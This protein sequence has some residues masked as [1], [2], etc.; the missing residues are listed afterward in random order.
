LKSIRRIYRWIIIS[1]FFQ[2]ALLSYINFFYLPGSRDV[3]ATMIETDQDTKTSLSLEMP[4]GAENV[5]VSFD[6]K[7]AAYM[8]NGNVVIADM[9]KMKIIKDLEPDKGEFSCF[10]WIPDREML[11]YA[12]KHIDGYSGRVQLSTYDIGAEL[13]RSY[14]VIKKLPNGSEIVEIETSPL[15]N[16]VYPIIK[17]NENEVQVY[18]FD[19]MD[20]LSYVMSVNIATTF[21]ETLFT[22]NLV[23]QQP[24]KKINVLNGETLKKKKLP[25]SEPDLLLD[26]DDSDNIYA[27]QTDENGEAIIIYSGKLDQESSDW[28]IIKLESPCEPDDIFITS[29]GGIFLADRLN[30]TIYCVDN[31]T[32]TAYSGEL[33]DVLDDYVVSIDDNNLLLQ[34]LEGSK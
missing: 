22:D 20:E 27:A 6:G 9:K 28:N 24:G 5:K 7:Y 21:K 34:V 2:V 32:G 13:D 10:E 23:Y 15:T 11:I 33:V 29:M 19:I 8:Y 26:V 16:I 31:D 30:S 4:D 18:K 12:Q 3:K 1:V 25:V 14:P 17:T